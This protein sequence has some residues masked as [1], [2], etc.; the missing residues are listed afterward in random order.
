MSEVT[1]AARDIPGKAGAGNWTATLVAR[2][3]VPD[4]PATAP[5]EISVGALIGRHPRVPLGVDRLL[6]PLR[7][8]GAVAVGPEGIGFDGKYMRWSRVREV[9]THTAVTMI[10]DSVIQREIDRIAK[11]LPRV[12]YR[13]WVVDRAIEGILTLLVAAVGTMEKVDLPVPCQI[14][15]RTRLFRTKEVSIGLVGTAFM[16]GMPQV[17]ASI[18]E[19]AR[20]N[21]VAVVPVI[22]NAV[23]TREERAERLRA[24]SANFA[25]RLRTLGPSYA[26]A[27]PQAHGTSQKRDTPRSWPRGQL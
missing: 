1:R 13:G 22:D 25:D 4:A 15:Y 21:N 3:P 26:E 7:R 24:A 10:V 11:L 27:N 16:A 17:N 5:W 2:L 18:I 8:F 23:I 6:R 9:R 19:T 20:A 12:P 14:V